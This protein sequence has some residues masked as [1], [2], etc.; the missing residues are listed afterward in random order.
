[1]SLSGVDAGGVQIEGLRRLR[2]TLR[3]A[4]DDLT[5]LRDLNR[6]AIAVVEPVAR[7]GAPLGPGDRGHI[8][9]TT[10]SSGTKTAAIIRVGNNGRF[11]YANPIHWGWVA[12]GIRP[13]PW[14]SRAAQQTEPVW[15]EIYFDGL[16]LII[17]KVEGA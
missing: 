3:R 5:D 6:K 16:R 8:R 15:T 7:T 10:R 13:N 9:D 11:P 1:M 2:S 17:R 12:R 14:V 4:G